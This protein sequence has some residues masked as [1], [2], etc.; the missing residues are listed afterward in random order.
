[1]TGQLGTSSTRADRRADAWLAVAFVG[2]TL[3]GLGAISRYALV[4]LIF[5]G[6]PAAAVVSAPIGLGLWLVPLFGLGGLP[7]RWHLLLGAALG[8]G[9][10]SLLVLLLG[11]LGILD[12]AVWIALLAAFALAG[13]LRLPMLLAESRS[14]KTGTDDKRNMGVSARAEFRRS[15]FDSWRGLKARGSLLWFVAIPFFVLALSAAANAPGTIRQ[16]EGY[17][18]DVLEYHLQVPKEYFLGGKITYA[19]HNV[20]ANFPMNVEMLYL[21]GMIVWGD[22]IEAAVTANFIHLWLGVLAVAGT[23]GAAR[24]WSRNA[25]VVSV[26]ALA[27]VGWLVYLAGLAYV[28]NGLLF[29]AMVATAAVVR[30]CVNGLPAECH[31]LVRDSY[32]A[33]EKGFPQEE[34]REGILAPAAKRWLALG[35]IAAGLSCGCKYTAG[36]MVALPLLVGA[37]LLPGRITR[38]LTGGLVFITAAAATFA[39]WLLKNQLMTGS[40]VFPLANGVFHASPPG[41]GEE[42]DRR[43]TAGHAPSLDERDLPA[44]LAASWNHIPADHY[45]RFGPAILIVPLAGLLWRKRTRV[46]W[47]LL[48]VAMLQICV[49]LFFTH[50]FARFAI[51]L[52]VPLA[53]LAGSAVFGA[54]R[55]RKIVIFGSVIVGAAWNFTFAARL[56]GNESAYG[57]HAAIFYEGRLPG[58]EYFDLVNQ[59]LPPSGK[60]LLVG[61]AK[62]FYFRK[63]V[64]Y[65]VVFNRNPFVEQVRAAKHDSDIIEW[66]QA[67]GYTHV[68]V[69]WSEVERLAGTYGLAPEITPQLFNRLEQAGLSLVRAY[70]HPHSQRQYVEV[71]SVPR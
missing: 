36:P 53:L 47:I 68:L 34:V 46:D 22:P 16:E 11:L 50:L 55:M 44:R 9:V 23:W 21:L 69:N 10:T 45:H 71:W 8:L 7:L 33:R 65:A 28:E 27:S 31:P 63:P 18:Y 38:K 35:G 20:Y 62:A 29:F 51:V 48:V 61:D 39:P 4:S 58:F 56:H 24:E 52:L 26:A 41:W 2:L 43:W 32:L 15:V 40:P 64:D 42:E 25:A 3:A 1:M 14:N 70:P 30:G 19:P 49:W 5:D 17:A 66:L 59:K 57:A 13:V 37:V 54:T 60:V 6:L 67:A 12:R